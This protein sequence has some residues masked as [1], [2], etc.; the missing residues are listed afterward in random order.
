MKRVRPVPGRLGAGTGQGAALLASLGLCPLA[1]LAIGTDA[2]APVAQAESIIAAERFLGVYVEPAVHEWTSG[3]RGLMTAA[4]VFYVVAHVPVAGWA[5]LWTWF[6][7]RDRFALVR[8]TFLWTQ[9]LLVTTYVLVPTAP[10][11]LVPGAGYADTL[12][13]LWGK[14]FANSA[15]LLQS[16]LAAMPSG[17]VAFALVAGG[18]FARLGDMAWLRAFGRTYP[19]VVVAVTVATANHLLLDA[20]AAAGVVAGAYRLAAWR[21]RRR[22]QSDSPREGRFDVGE[23]A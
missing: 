5:L 6:V 13:G 16:P 21:T 23:L 2:D 8:D 9:L 3:H 14:E 7:R 22:P 11:R 1:A 15:H 18:V 19:A 4:S 10:P 20:L 12:T 17:H